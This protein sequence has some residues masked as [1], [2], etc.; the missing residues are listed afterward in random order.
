MS[1]VRGS[2]CPMHSSFRSSEA[3]DLNNLCCLLQAG[4][5]FIP[6]L[7]QDNLDLS[8]VQTQQVIQ[9]IDE[10]LEQLLRLPPQQF[11]HVVCSDESLHTCLDSFLRFK[12]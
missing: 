9:A 3:P 6:F 8:N 5:G 2:G 4:P 11:W 7:L 12:R 1:G 10:D